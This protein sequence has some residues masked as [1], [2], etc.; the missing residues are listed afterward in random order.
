MAMSRALKEL[1]TN[2]R[3]KH[4]ISIVTR[5]Y[6]DDVLIIVDETY[7]ERVV[8]ELSRIMEPFGWILKHTKSQAYIPRDV[9]VHSLTTPLR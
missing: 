6:L 7:A 9:D 4:G 2:T 5:A 1:E 3:A 8:N